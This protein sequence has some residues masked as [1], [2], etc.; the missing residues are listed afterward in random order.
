ML[1]WVEHAMQSVAGIEDALQPVAVEDFRAAEAWLD[2]SYAA[3]P[4]EAEA[5]KHWM[6]CCA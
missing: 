4:G 1:A 3:L 5:Q 2:L 6:I